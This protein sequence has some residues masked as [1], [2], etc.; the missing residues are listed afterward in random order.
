MSKIRTVIE[1]PRPQGVDEEITYRFNWSDVGTPTVPAV[2]I[3]DHNGT[4][5]SALCLT[6]AP[7]I[8]GN[9]VLTP[10]VAD[11]VAGEIY[12]L[13]CKATIGG[14]ILERVC[15]IVGEE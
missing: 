6:G 8:V 2:V 1:S 9:Y 4:D 15:E 12:R 5:V 11:L 7:S 10:V 3:K 13:E 14:N